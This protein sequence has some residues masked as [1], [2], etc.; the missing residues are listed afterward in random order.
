M[1]RRLFPFCRQM[2][3]ALE[4]SDR[5]TGEGSRPPRRSGIAIIS[6]SRKIVLVCSFSTGYRLEK[7]RQ[8]CLFGR[9]FTIFGVVLLQ[10]LEHDLR[11]QQ[12][13]FRQHIRHHGRSAT[14]RGQ[15]HAPALFLPGRIKRTLRIGEPA[16]I[17]LVYCRKISPFRLSVIPRPVRSNSGV[18]RD[19][20][21]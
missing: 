19:L 14:R 11:M 18:C 9:I 13:E 20:F 21:Q 8:V 6:S 3:S 2:N 5:L 10:D 15:R 4:K 16:R 1:L 17:R 7:E 12:L